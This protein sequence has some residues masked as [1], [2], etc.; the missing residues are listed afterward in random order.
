MSWGDERK[1]MHAKNSYQSRTW[2]RDLSSVGKSEHT[3]ILYM[4]D[5]YESAWIRGYI[6]CTLV[7]F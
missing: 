4:L 6:E 3:G 1:K 2:D 7:P 5:P